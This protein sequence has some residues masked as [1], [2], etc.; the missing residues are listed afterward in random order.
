MLVNDHWLRHIAP[1]WWT[2]KLGD[3]AWLFFFP[4]AFALLLALVVPAHWERREAIVQVIAYGLI[5]GVFVLGKTIPGFRDWLVAFVTPLFGYAITVVI[6]P[7]DLIALGALGASGWCWDRDKNI[8]PLRVE[9]GALALA[10]SAALTLAD[11]AAPLQGAFTFCTYGS[12][13]ITSSTRGDYYRARE[14]GLVWQNLPTRYEQNIYQIPTDD[15]QTMWVDPE[16]QLDCVRTEKESQLLRVNA[17]VAYRYESGKTIE[18]TND[19]G[20]TWNVVYTLSMTQAAQR[21]YSFRGTVNPGPLN[22]FVE[23]KS[24]NV[25]FA[26]GQE[27]V[28][29]RRADGPWTWVAVGRYRHVEFNQFEEIASVLWGESWLAVGLALLIL[30][31]L[32]HRLHPTTLRTILLFSYWLFWGANAIL[33][34]GILHNFG[35]YS[36]AN[37]LVMLP[38]CLYLIVLIAL[39]VPKV[40]RYSPALF[41]RLVAFAIAGGVLF[42][43]SY[44]LW[45]RNLIPEYL[46]ALGI[47]LAL[48]AVTLFIGWRT[49]REVAGIF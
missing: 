15:A 18:Q 41:A 21:E 45:T 19:G 20:A 43:A 3:I 5:G 6:D 9:W 24:G 13:I 29:V 39:D 14:G 4:F 34:D 2:G 37:V 1:S 28:L 48:G 11:Q 16:R 7:S 42:F 27:G 35:N 25:L 30:L 46:I 10:A 32:L 44:V 33:F 23:P 31:T 26:M 40:L 17:N 36:G 12:E 49:T 47:A 22:A 8:A 38:G